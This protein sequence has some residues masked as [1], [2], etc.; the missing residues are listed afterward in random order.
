MWRSIWSRAR[1]SPTLRGA[2]L[3]TVPVFPTFCADTMHSLHPELTRA[4][5]AMLD[6]LEA[7]NSYLGDTAWVC[8]TIVQ[9]CSEML[10]ILGGG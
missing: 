9:V 8:G 1:G 5:G 2:R 6:K 7:L 3:L 10:R 4:M